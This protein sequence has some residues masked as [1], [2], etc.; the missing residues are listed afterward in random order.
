[1]SSTIPSPT[2]VTAMSDSTNFATQQLHR[3]FASPVPSRRVQWP[4]DVQSSAS[5]VPTAACFPFPLNPFERES[6]CT[7]SAC[8]STAS[9]SSKTEVWSSRPAISFPES[10]RTTLVP[11]ATQWSTPTIA[12]DAPTGLIRSAPTSPVGTWHWTRG[13][14]W[15][16]IAVRRELTGRSRATAGSL[17]STIKRSSIRLIERDE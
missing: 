13:I 11:S 17:P 16:W 1:M 5:S 14:E 3:D 4:R 9:G 6:Q 12:S 15:S 2:V 7:S 10:C 8:S